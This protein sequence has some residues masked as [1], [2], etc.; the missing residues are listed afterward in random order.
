MPDLSLMFQE[1]QAVP[2][3]NVLEQPQTISILENAMVL[4]ETITQRL[5]PDSFEELS[6]LPQEYI[7]YDAGAG[8]LPFPFLAAG[9]DDEGE[10]LDEDED[11]D[12]MDDGFDDDDS[13]DDDSDF[14]DDDNDYEDEEDDYNYEEDVDYDDFDE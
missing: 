2:R 13:F 1:K 7:A 3:T 10:D 11:F 8:G 5:Y 12:D 4:P 6:L 14:D 9:D